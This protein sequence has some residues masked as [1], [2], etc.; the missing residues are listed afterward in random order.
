LERCGACS[1]KSA[2]TKMGVSVASGHHFDLASL[3]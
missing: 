2:E 1:G 3:T